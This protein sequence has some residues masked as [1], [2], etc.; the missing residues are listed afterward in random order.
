MREQEFLQELKEMN[1]L[2]QAMG[3]LGW[4]SQTGMPEKASEE[5]SEVD[6]YLYGLYFNKL[7]GPKVKEAVDYFGEHPDELSEV[8]KAAYEVVKK[9]Y[10]LNQSVPQEKMVEY[11]AAM[12]KAHTRLATISK[13]QR[14]R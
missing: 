1:L 4:D 2:M 8:G 11:S 12:S 7:I 10:E 3:I 6:S 14:F 9:D 5:R 13:K